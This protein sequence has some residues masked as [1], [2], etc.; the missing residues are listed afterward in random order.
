MLL[1]VVFFAEA[2]RTSSRRKATFVENDIEDEVSES[3]APP[4]VI[5]KPTKS[6]SNRAAAQ[7][8]QRSSRKK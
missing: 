8:L 7:G 3:D 6:V 4:S 5:R 2:V 1:S